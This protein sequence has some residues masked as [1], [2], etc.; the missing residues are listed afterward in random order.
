MIDSDSGLVYASP[1]IVGV[2]L[3]VAQGFIADPG[4]TILGVIA[5]VLIA[6]RVLR[7]LNAN[8]NG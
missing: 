8:L 2:A 1:Y 7:D 5:L 4:Q 3:L 6:G